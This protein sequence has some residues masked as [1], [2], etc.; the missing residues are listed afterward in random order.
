MVE[1]A[2]SQKNVA[3]M[4]NAPVFFRIF[5]KKATRCLRPPFNLPLSQETTTSEEN[6]LACR[7]SYSTEFYNLKVDVFCHA[8]VFCASR[9]A[10]VASF[11]AG[12]LKRH[13]SPLPIH[14][15]KQHKQL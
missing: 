14:R 1:F 6:C 5:A 7:Y 10:C 11:M 2:L 15:E 9:L 13:A 3:V 4:S 8:F 12:K